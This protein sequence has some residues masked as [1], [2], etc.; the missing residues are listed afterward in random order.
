MVILVIPVIVCGRS[1]VPGCDTPDLGGGNYVMNDT[2]ILFYNVRFILIYSLKMSVVGVIIPLLENKERI[3]K[4]NYQKFHPIC[5][6]CGHVSPESQDRIC[7]L[8]KSYKKSEVI[9]LD[10]NFNLVR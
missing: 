1:Q 10:E 9:T 6:I 4:M 5:Q 8:D 3:E 7:P 2:K